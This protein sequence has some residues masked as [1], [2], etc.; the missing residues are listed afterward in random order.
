MKTYR[1]PMPKM[2]VKDIF[3]CTLIL[4]PHSIG[5]GRA[6]T[7]ASRSTP[8]V[9]C[10]TK[11]LDV[12]TQ[13]PSFIVLS[14]LNANGLQDANVVMVKA[15]PY[16]MMKHNTAYATWWNLRF[17]KITMNKWS[18]DTFTSVTARIPSISITTNIWKGQNRRYSTQ[19]Y[20][21]RMKIH[22]LSANTSSS[23]ETLFW[24]WPTPPWVTA[25]LSSKSAK[26][27]SGITFRRTEI[28]RD[29]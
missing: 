14:Q 3:F 11:Y 20:Y 5:I 9:V 19:D 28:H 24:C 15:M 18:A 6:T 2:H 22:T 21:R 13:T 26:S 4:S 12:S 10:A 17:S 23:R 8:E 7:R 1:M 27:S 25:A 29:Y 16:N